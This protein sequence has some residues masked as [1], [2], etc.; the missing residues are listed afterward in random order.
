MRKE[1]QKA[2]VVVAAAMIATSIVSSQERIQT[3][4]VDGYSGSVPVKQMNGKNYVEVEAVARVVNGSLS[5]KGN[6]IVLKLSSAGKSDVAASPSPTVPAGL[7]KE[8]LRAGNEA[9]SVIRDW[10]STLVSSFENQSGI[11]QDEL[12]GYQSEAMTSLQAE[13]AAVTTDA[14][15]KVAQLLANQYQQMKD[16]S[17]K[18]QAKRVNM[19]YIEPGALK[20]DSL[21]QNIAACGKLLREIMASGQFA[22]EPICR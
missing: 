3:V 6:Q 10:H 13:Q 2:W 12:A 22:E 7:S 11:T 14:D 16:L 17:D 15:Q 21:D 18:Y 19:S 9:M 8:F 4:V 5:F 20:N 1:V